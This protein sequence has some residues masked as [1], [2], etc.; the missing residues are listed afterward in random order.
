MSPNHTRRPAA[1]L[2]ATAS[3]GLALAG[4]KFD[5]RP[6]LARGDPAQDIYAAGPGPLD[7]YANTLSLIHI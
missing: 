5:N 2:F 4:C 7:P 6:L 3:V 1:I